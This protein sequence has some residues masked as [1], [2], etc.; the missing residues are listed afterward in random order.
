VVVGKRFSLAEAFGDFCTGYPYLLS[1]DVPDVPLRLEPLGCVLVVPEG[2]VLLVSGFDVSAGGS[3]T[4]IGRIPGWVVLAGGLGSYA[5]NGGFGVSP[6]LGGS[7]WD[8]GGKS[9]GWSEVGCG[10]PGMMPGGDC[11]G[12]P[13][14]DCGLS[15]ITCGG[16]VRCCT[17]LA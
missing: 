10:L 15:S 2:S 11:G 12:L 3:M 4:G 7:I 6:G 17:S 8:F 9:P 16:I 5:G 1:S 13:F 14:C